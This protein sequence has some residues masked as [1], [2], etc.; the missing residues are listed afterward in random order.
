MNKIEALNGRTFAVKAW[1]ESTEVIVLVFKYQEGGAPAIQLRKNFDFSPFATLTVNIPDVKLGE[2]EIL[3]KGWSENE[4]VADA[5][6]KTGW[7][8]RTNKIVPTGFAVAEV[9]RVLG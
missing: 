8:E 4:P 3:I 1:G 2:D 5:A 9:W 7:F 6:M